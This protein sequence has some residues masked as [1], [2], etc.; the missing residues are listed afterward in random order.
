MG[1]VSYMS[2]EQSIGEGID[3]RTDIWSFGV[4]LYE[5]LAGCLP[6]QGKDI[7]RQIIAI[8]E[9]EAPSLA[10]LVEGVPDRLEEIV[11]KCLAKNKDERYQ[12]AKDL[13]ID[14][15]NL[16]RKLD[17]DAEIERS[18]TS[19]LRSTSG[20]ASRAS[21][22]SSQMNAA[23]TSA[24]QVSTTS[25]AEYVVTGI[26]QH[27]VA[28]AIMVLVLIAGGIGLGLF[29]RARNTEGVIDSIAVLPFENRSNIAD[30]EYL[31]DGL[32]E[33]LIYR[34]SQLPDLKVS[35]TS[36][37]MRYKGKG[38]NLKTIADELGVSAVMTGRLVQRGD[39]LTISVE[40]IDVRNNN[41]L[42]GE[43]Y[44]RKMTDL[45]AMQRAIS[46]EIINKLQ[47]K[48]SGEG[49]QKLAKKYTD[50]NEA[51][52]LYLK[53]RF[54]WN[55]RKPESL[56]QAVEF[57]K[58]AIEKDPNYAL[59]YSGLA[60][61]YVL[62]SFYGVAPA[63]ESMPKAKTAIERAL[64]IDDSLAEA[65]AARGKYLAFYEYDRTGSEREFRRAIELNPNYATAHQWLGLDF[66]VLTKRFD[67][68]I[69][70]LKRAGEIDPL[71]PVIGS[72]T[73]SALGYAG[74][75]DEAIEQ[76]RRTL[77]LEPGFSYA[78]SMLGY[79]LDGKGQFA[80]AITEYEKAI[81][82]SDDGYTR[83]VLIRAL[84]KS[85]K[86]SEAERQM[87]ALRSLA[88]RSYVPNFCFAIAYTAL[89]D[90]ETAIAMLAKDVEERSSYVSTLG[91]ELALNELH[92][93]PRFKAL[94]KR[95]NLAE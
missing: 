14:L 2:P 45:L 20:G 81:A 18:V 65:H 70:E 3:Q 57:Y 63:K 39:N 85:G 55:K 82:L 51:F 42:W 73:A 6:F 11:T 15:R 86:R 27:K 32:A 34:L 94:L 87:E 22:Q 41:L 48:L 21:T 8:Q 16:R 58:Q 69:R 91:I 1:T 68:G 30:T 24:A 40:L 59:A 49:E 71:S 80:E 60:E 72:D 13:L 62:F 76:S 28:A 89:G 37:V 88:S 95:L 52:Q 36:S 84:M 64:T 12:T 43:Q 53:G 17:V 46:T 26:R 67:E 90:K 33:S 38:G 50:S 74:R 66:L 19:G 78:H 79:A 7:H 47:L 23:T 9:T 61:T 5:M 35:P 56:K 92:D 44:D 75:F 54:A 83:A 25:S 4:L 31:S 93:D 29:M 77:A 10:T